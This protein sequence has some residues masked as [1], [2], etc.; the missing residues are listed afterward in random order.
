MPKLNLAKRKDIKFEEQENTPGM[1]YVT[2]SREARWTW[3]SIEDQ[4][5]GLKHLNL[6]A[7]VKRRLSTTFRHLSNNGCDG[8]QIFGTT[9]GG[10]AQNHV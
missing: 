8:P 1:S 5:V 2:A 6:I 4:G 7:V 3:F 9:E 10:G